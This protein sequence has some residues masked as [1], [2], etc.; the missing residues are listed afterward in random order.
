[1]R[2]IFLMALGF[3]FLNSCKTVNYKD[4]VDDEVIFNTVTIDTLFQDNISIRAI[5]VDGNKIWYAANN[6]RFGFFDLEKNKKFERKISKDT[7]TLEFRSIAQTPKNIFLLSVANPGLLYKVNKENLETTLVYQEYNEKVFYDSMKFW[8]KNEG[9]AMGDPITDYLSIIITRDGGNSWN[10]ISNS[11]LPKIVDGEAAFAASNT[12]IVIK[13]NDTW[14]VSGGK[15]A[16]VFY[17]ADKGN[18][19]EVFDTPIVQGKAMAGIFTADFYDSKNGF[20]AGGDYEAPNQNFGNKARTQDGGKTWELMAENEGFG[21][22]SCVQYVPGSNGK[23]LVTVGA[24]GLYYSAD[25]GNS[26][27]QLTTD[28]SLFTIRFLDNHTAIA[29]GKNKMIRINFIK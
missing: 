18:N 13:G 6:S 3:V 17:S 24:S 25:R 7:L 2:N 19:W 11:K 10:K 29:A 5:T 9:I 1:M 27:R 8:N 28:P 14:I 23:S 12:N 15:K 20:I 4:T 22:A 16:R 21:Y 26:W